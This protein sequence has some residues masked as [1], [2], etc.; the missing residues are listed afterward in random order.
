MCKYRVGFQVLNPGE[1]LQLRVAEK[2]VE[3]IVG[4]GRSGRKL[5][6][7]L[8]EFICGNQGKESFSCESQGQDSFLKR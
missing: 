1:C 3:G 4:N 8:Q 2:L 5:K 7:D 6:E